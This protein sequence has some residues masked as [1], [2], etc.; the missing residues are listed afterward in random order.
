MQHKEL[1]ASKR[2]LR[3]LQ[4]KASRRPYA[5]IMI[6]GDGYIF[7]EQYVRQGIRGGELAA[8]LFREKIHHYFSQHNFPDIGNWDLK[9]RIFVNVEGLS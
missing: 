1:V 6:D 3:F 7:H 4:A 2:S 8:N 5:L 9:I